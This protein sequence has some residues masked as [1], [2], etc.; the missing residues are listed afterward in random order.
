MQTSSVINSIELSKALQTS[1]LPD[2]QKKEFETML[3]QMNEEEKARVQALIEKANQLKETFEKQKAA[4][5]NQLNQ[6]AA[7]ALKNLDRETNKEVLGAVEKFDAD[8]TQKELN[9]L[10][11]NVVEEIKEPISHENKSIQAPKNPQ[12]TKTFLLILLGVVL[13]MG[14]LIFA[15][16]SL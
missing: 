10:D 4:K 7:V 3:P 12:V 8:Q 13:V 6:E 1:A 9:D 16:I 11:L 2:E 15:L 14:T 5:L